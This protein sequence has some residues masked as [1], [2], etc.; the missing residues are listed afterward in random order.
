[1]ALGANLT[2]TALRAASLFCYVM[3]WISAII[4]TGIVGNFLERFSNR[5]VDIV[6]MEVIVCLSVPQLVILLSN[7]RAPGCHNNGCLPRWSD[8]AMLTQVWR[9]YGAY[10]SHLQLSLAHGVHLCRSGLEPPSMQK[11][12]P[13]IWALWPEACN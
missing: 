4:V 13:S 11:F 12:D 5:G 6:Y 8:F 10:A 7:M 1:M 9:L 2:N 3:T